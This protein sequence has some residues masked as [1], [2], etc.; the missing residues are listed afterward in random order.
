MATINASISTPIQSGSAYLFLFLGK[1]SRMANAILAVLL[2][3]IGFLFAGPIAAAGPV[4]TNDPREA[5]RGE[6]LFKDSD[7][8]FQAAPLLATEVEINVNGM[9]AHGKVKQHFA[10]PYKEWMEGLY[11]F[12][13]PDTAA[14]D[15]L[16]LK[17]GEREIEGTIKER[18]E[19]RRTYE[20]AARSG[21][22]AGLLEQ[23][24]PNIFTAAVANIAPG[25]TVTVEMTY[26]QDV[27]YTA[28]AGFTL[29]FPLAITPRYEPQPVQV[30][31]VSDR[32]WST[33]VKP[34]EEPAPQPIFR[35]PD[36]KAGNP[37]TMKVTV[38]L[39]LPLSEIV[40]T[41]HQISTTTQNDITSVSL[42]DQIVPADRDFI[43]N[44]KPELGKE[45][46]AALFQEV[47]GG[48]DHLLLMVMPPQP[49]AHSDNDRPARE[50][51][52]ILDQ[53]GSMSG[54]SINQARQGLEL[55]LSR[56][57]PIDR[58][59]VIRFNDTPTMLFPKT[60]T[61]SEEAVTTARN[62]VKNTE[63]TGGT[64]MRSALDMA[65]NAAPTPG[66]LHQMVFLTDGAV[67]NEAELFRTIR[68]RIGE[69]RMFTVG[70]G[71]APNGYFM[72]KAAAFG[73]GTYVYIHKPEEVGPQMKALFQKLERAEL[74]DLTVAFPKDITA[75][76]APERLPDLYSGEPLVITA[77]LAKDTKLAQDAQITITGK[78]AGKP[79]AM[80]L[81]LKG[82]NSAEGVAALWARRAIESQLDRRTEG[83][84]E[85][86]VK[87]AV[88]E[89]ALTH[90]LM[91]PYT[92]FV[93]V[94]K[95]PARPAH[96]R[97]VPGEVPQ[98]L[99]H[100][101]VPP[102]STDKSPNTPTQTTP[103]KRAGA[104]PGDGEVTKTET[105]GYQPA[106]QSTTEPPM[107]PIDTAPS[108]Q[109]IIN[110]LAQGEDIDA[111]AGATPAALQAITGLLAV[112]LGAALLFW[113]RSLSPGFLNWRR[114]GGPGA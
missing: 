28:D 51:T 66:F 45:P 106:T 74:T 103:L 85:A 105:R 113:R 78:L 110:M 35:E 14:V 22:R 87:S 101:W 43:L 8:A 33:S 76:V 67:G 92:S 3:M 26:R 9:V 31:M 91:S 11:V 7:G 10:N 56:L 71:A 88:L 114:R 99:P 49:I 82:R 86:D 104:S 72:R 97:L 46:K 69:M 64:E 29:R 70:I 25:E 21:Q 60:V 17:I 2:L 59:N 24:R 18:E 75:E 68:D 40:S 65:L 37:V 38:D 94:D 5:K 53:S 62:F 6:F 48:Q 20:A 109:T 16:K 84:D 39:G 23:K 15:S 73:R 111:P 55:A 34:G 102:Q 57:R 4:E 13:L 50:I 32:G 96:D 47:V 100:G 1:L 41:S 98:N 81:P 107:P 30:D 112:L 108:T 42:K 54:A 63:A 36:E 52:F 93:A 19:A 95:T 90:R 79:F 12:P 89:L 44:W 83:V 27:P 58:F 61:A 80:G 77:R